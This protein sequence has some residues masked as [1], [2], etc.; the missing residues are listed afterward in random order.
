MFDSTPMDFNE[1]LAWLGEREGHRTVL[2]ITGPNE[3]DSPAIVRVDAPLGPMKVVSEGQALSEA[4]IGTASFQVGDALVSMFGPE[5]VRGEHLA[6]MGWVVVHQRHAVFEW[7]I[8][9][10]GSDDG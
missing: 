8:P 2:L 4:V 6:D 7:R 3:E 10:D 9:R 5:F 1:V